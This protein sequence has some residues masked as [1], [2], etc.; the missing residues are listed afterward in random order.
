MA[1]RLAETSQSESSFSVK[2]Y[3]DCIVKSVG[4]RFFVSV[5]LPGRI[6]FIQLAGFLNV[7]QDCVIDLDLWK[8][9]VKPV[10]S[11][12]VYIKS[13][14][15]SMPVLNIL[16]NSSSGDIAG[17]PGVLELKPPV[18]PSIFNIPSKVKAGADL[19]LKDFEVDFFEI[20]SPARHKFFLVGCLAVHLIRIG[21]EFLREVLE[22]FFR[23][24]R[25][26]F[27]VC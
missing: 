17:C 20:H 9:H 7:F 12:R 25:K 27:V 6:F 23:E 18:T 5:H 11:P 8:K 10:L 22:L 2:L 14:Y 21:M 19:A 4:K 24:V 16:I 13:L 15:K 3:R 26:G 1:F